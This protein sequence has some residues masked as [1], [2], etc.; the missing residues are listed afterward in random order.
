MLPDSG[1][2]RI[3]ENFHELP[4]CSISVLN[5]KKIKGFEPSSSYF[6]IEFAA[7]DMM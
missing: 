2:P 6:S 5:I 7:K 1:D 4:K 3:L